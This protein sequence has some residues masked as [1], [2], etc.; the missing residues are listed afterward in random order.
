MG[1][2][3]ALGVGAEAGAPPAH[4]RDVYN[5]FDCVKDHGAWKQW[6]VMQILD[7]QKSLRQYAGPG[8]SNDP[9]MLEVG[10]GM[11]A[12]EDR[13]HFS[14]WRMLARRSSPE[15]TCARCHA[16]QGTRSPTGR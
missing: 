9:D 3:Q 8:H 2:A 5:C 13:A 16:R 10:N 7:M 6:G 14:M 11:S 12:S 1:A 15:T 4:D